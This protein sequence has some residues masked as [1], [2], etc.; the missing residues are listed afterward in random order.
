M[1]RYW[2]T[3]TTFAVLFAVLLAVRTGRLQ[4]IYPSGS[5]APVSLSDALSG[6]DTWM[7]IHQAGNKIGYSHAI[8]IPRGD[9]YLLTEELHMGLK[10]MGL[11]Q[12]LALH[13]EGVLQSDLALSSFR[14]RMS[15]GRFRFEA[16]GEVSGNTLSVRLVAP[17]NPQPVT[18]GIE[19]PIYLSSA[20]LAAVG[21]M[22]LGTGD[23][24][25]FHIFDPATM[26]REPVTI[27]VAG[28]EE[29]RIMGDMLATTRVTLSF[30][31]ATQSAWI[32][33]TGEVLR[34]EG[35]LGITS[36]KTTPLEARS[37]FTAGSGGDLAGLA[38]VA[39][40]V[41][42]QDPVRLVL[43]K[44]E[45]GGVDLGRLRLGRGRQHLE[46][47]VLLIQKEGLAPASRK[48]EPED[49]EPGKADLES[50]PFIQS[51]HP[52]IRDLA[53]RIVAGRDGT[54]SMVSGL[55]S[56]IRENIERRPVISLPDAL[57]TLKNRSGDCNEHAVLMAALARAVGI[58]TEIEAGLVYLDG[59]FYYHAW[60][61]V[62]AG[63]WISVDATFGQIP[64]D[65]THIRLASG[66]LDGQ[67]DL[68][69]V[70]GRLR[71]TVLDFS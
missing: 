35:F 53:R 42:I 34:E 57:S 15:S 48:G 8:L 28:K 3:G 18:I 40:N 44:V 7:S 54:L 10:I 6:R 59:R 27:R 51:E 5:P 36:E 31:G 56:W 25:T 23:R 58:P 60:N 62:Y 30:R 38:S 52:E 69:G 21:T 24:K 19:A 55:V 63:G 66:G 67:M 32:G 13:M 2:I 22:G 1:K 20:I 49:R 43:L 16:K 39:S 70:I 47:N 68:I 37:G 17:E 29:I 71:L 9:G 41:P 65:V 4:R 61:R 45:I 26:S 64:A 46:G 50:T 11:A 33:E 12:N 14:F